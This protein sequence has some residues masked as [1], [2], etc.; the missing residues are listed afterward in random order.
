MQTDAAGAGVLQKLDAGGGKGRDSIDASDWQQQ[1]DEHH[2]HH[3][4]HQQQ[5][6][7]QENRRDVAHE[8]GQGGVVVVGPEEG[9]TVSVFECL[10]FFYPQ[11]VLLVPQQHSHV[12]LHR[13]YMLK[14][15][16]RSG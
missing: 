7:Q 8:F 2:H 12:F 10:L 5:Q 14:R 9:G 4:H 1:Q 15:V 16:F 6:Q 13:L 3:H 11:R